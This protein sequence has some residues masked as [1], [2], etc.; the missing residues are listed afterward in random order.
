MNI[1][2]KIF[3]GWPVK[4]EVISE[5]FLSCNDTKLSKNQI[6]NGIKINELI[7]VNNHFFVDTCILKKVF[8]H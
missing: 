5:W 1:E 6:L 8:S 7:L 4:N 3:D 2:N